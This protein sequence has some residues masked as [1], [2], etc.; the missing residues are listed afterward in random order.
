M[1]MVDE[2]GKIKWTEGD[3]VSKSEKGNSKLTLSG[4]DCKALYLASDD[5]LYLKLELHEPVGQDIQYVFVL[6]LEK[7]EKALIYQVFCRPE[8]IKLFEIR[9]N[10][11]KEIEPGAVE[12]SIKLGAYEIELKLSYKKLGLSGIT[13]VIPQVIVHELGKKGVI[14]TDKEQFVAIEQVETI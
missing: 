6:N 14:K 5:N 8:E 7:G 9:K 2:K 10:K 11:E 3:L 1:K 4:G 12:S 13:G